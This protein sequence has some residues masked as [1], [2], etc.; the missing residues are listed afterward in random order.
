MFQ[1][2]TSLNQELLYFEEDNTFFFIS[3]HVRERRKITGNRLPSEPL[4]HIISIGFLFFL[5]QVIFGIMGIALPERKK[6]S[7]NAHLGT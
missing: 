3:T 6:G 2:Y 4:S 1:I 5:L 7:T